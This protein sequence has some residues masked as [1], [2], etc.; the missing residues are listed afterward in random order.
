M[1]YV[2]AMH[3]IPRNIFGILHLKLADR[4]NGWEIYGAAQ[5]CKFTDPELTLTY[6]HS[7][8]PKQ[9]AAL[10]CSHLQTRSGTKIWA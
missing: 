6:D 7:I 5:S 2:C 4:V 10:S 8:P 1:K 3:G 9:Q